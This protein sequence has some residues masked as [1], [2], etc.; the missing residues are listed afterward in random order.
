MS[1]KL[2]FTALRASL[3]YVLVA[4]IWATMSDLLVDRLISE[5][6]WALQ[7][8]FYSDWLFVGITGILLFFIL[9]NHAASYN[10]KI[11]EVQRAE[12]MANLQR[13][14]MEKIADGKPLKETL[15]GLL[16]GIET[17]MQNAKVSILLLDSD[18]VHLRHGAAPSLPEEYNRAIDGAVIGPKVGSCGTAAYR[19]SPVFVSDIARDPLWTDYKHLA[20]PHGLRA[21][22]STPI[23]EERK[24]IVGTFAVYRQKPGL[25]TDEEVRMIEL[26]THT[27]AAAI[28]KHRAEQSRHESEA[29]FHLLVDHASDAIFVHDVNGKLVD[30]NPMA[31]EELGY[32]REELL[33]M[34]VTEIEQDINLPEAQE[35]WRKLQPGQSEILRGRHRRKD[36]TTFP[37][38]VNLTCYK[39]QS[40]LVI[41]GLSRNLNGRKEYE[42]QLAQ[43]VS[44]LRSTIE[45]T[46]SGLLVVDLT[47]KL[48]I[49]N[50]RFLEMWRIPADIAAQRDDQTLLKMVV[51]QMAEPESFLR[52]VQ[53][54]YER[55]EADSREIIQFKDGR[56]FDR[57][58]RPQRLGD[59]IIGRVWSFRDITEQKR[60]EESVKHERQLLRTLVDLAPD[61]IFIK[62]TASRFLVVNEALASCYRQ[63]PA[64]MLGHADADFVSAELATR[65][66]QS[67]LKVLETGTLHIYEDTIC[68]PDGKIRTVATNMMAFRDGNGQVGG[69]IGIGHDITSQKQA[70]KSARLQSLALNTAANAVLITDPKGN[71]EWANPAFS[72]TSGFTLAECL[73][74]NPREFV[75]SGKHSK[76]FFE[77]MWKTIL[78]GKVWHGE[79]TNRRKDGSFYQEEMTITPLLDEQNRVTHFVA[80]KQDVTERKKNTETLLTTQAL[81]SSLVEQMPVCVFRKDA[82][83]RFEYVNDRFCK[84][85]QLKREEIIGR[86]PLEMAEYNLSRRSNKNLADTSDYNF[87]VLGVNHHTAIMKNGQ[88]IEV[89]EEYI[90]ADGEVRY[91]HVF[92]TP[93]FDLNKKIIGSQGIMFDMTERRHTDEK[94]RQANERTQF[95]MSRLPLA[96]IAWDQDF[97]VTEWN[98]AAEKIFGWKAS[99]AM[100]KHAYK[101]I[102]P[103]DAQPIVN[104]VWQEVIAGGNLTSH[105]VNDNVNKDG[106]R[107]TCEW[108][109]MPWRNTLGQIAGC[110]SIVDD[111]TERIQN[112]KQR[113]ELEIQLRQSQKMEAIGQLS[114]GIAHDF[115]N[116][117]T[118][119]QGNAA[120][121]Q[122]LDLQPEET[123][124]CSKQIARAAERAAGLTRQLLMFARKQDMRLVNLDLNE[125]VAQITKML[126]RILGEDI[127]LSTEYAPSLPP[128]Q[129]DIG[130]MEQIVMNLAV[131]ARDAMAKGGKLTLR[132]STEKRRRKKSEPMETFVRLQ[133]I[134]TGCGIAPEILP[135]IFEPFFT[136]K[137]IGKGT[138]LGLAT[139]YGIVQQHNGTIDVQSELGKGTTFTIFFPA[140]SE[141]EIIHAMPT[142]KPSLPLGN[143]TILL[144]EDEFP[145]RTFVSDLLQRCGYTVLE[146]ESGPSAIKIWEQKRGQID[147]LFTDVIM[148]EGMNG[149]E[150]GYHLLKEKPTLKIVYT[151]GYTG[152]IE[153]RHATLVEGGNFIRK[154]YK[155]EALATLIRKKLDEKNAAR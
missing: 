1:Q 34:S 130:M 129:A 53:E 114:G 23:F 94:L 83:G 25:P 137:E 75:K 151:S 121:L 65:F 33:Q 27:V 136:T 141:I 95:Y 12:T 98:T 4:L 100:G 46:L 6:N 104:K 62:D 135:R 76:E 15:E 80:I 37:V 51:E 49:Y 139:V 39:F 152:N 118:V 32:S 48:T 52:R 77:G 111:I 44:L 106:R 149:I 134:D 45:S 145:L 103:P 13:E 147:L 40:Q 21:C 122:N 91:F 131:N 140:V 60:A 99:D 79:L 47:G 108:R 74:K 93:V 126:Q 89:D 59:K 5:R 14:T 50:N 85:K 67:E 72:N 109:N 117:L 71:I 24:N 84:L 35:L 26:M 86:T 96:F 8:E 155:P 29:R 68:F 54:I 31:C 116:I 70:E 9:R 115:N 57:V 64:A 82:A 7:F 90:A 18:R 30:V 38:E 20:L 110:L 17:Q 61:F 63:Q 138:G 112:E 28:A 42:E 58:S 148:P 132:T 81:Y 22:W 69:L 102:V 66:R 97:C 107:L 133:V 142:V 119:I 56:V 78:A 125:T 36:G 101:L 73:G 92:K 123:R 154:P 120:L 16:R 2:K 127:T 11:R 128:I 146:A 19:G 113:N 10:Q 143:E 88:T 144:V 150:L 124:D 41:A 3:L 153:G 55:P 87:S 43:S 105:S